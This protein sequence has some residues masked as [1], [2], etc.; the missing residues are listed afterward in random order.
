[1][2]SSQPVNDIR[3]GRYAVLLFFALLAAGLAGNYFK[4]HLLNLHFIFGSIFAM[5]AL[6]YF[7]GQ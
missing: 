6:Q 1:M 3:T 7:G 5:L 4:F 2:S